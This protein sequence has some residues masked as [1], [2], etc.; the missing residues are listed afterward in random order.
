TASTISERDALTGFPA[1][2]GPLA[3]RA[4]AAD[5]VVRGFDVFGMRARTLHSLGVACALLA[6]VPR[7]AIIRVSE[8]WP[9]RRSHAAKCWNSLSPESPLILSGGMGWRS[10]APKRATIRPPP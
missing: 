7:P 1:G 9:K 10:N 3:G 6:R 4:S 8:P 2:L 5:S